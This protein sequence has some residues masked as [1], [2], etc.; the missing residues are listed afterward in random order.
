MIYNWSCFWK[1]F[2]ANQRG[3][4]LSLVPLHLAFKTKSISFHVNWNVNSLLSYYLNSTVYKKE[5]QKAKEISVIPLNRHTVIQIFPSLFRFFYPQQFHKVNRVKNSPASSQMH[6][7]SPFLSLLLLFQTQEYTYTTS[8]SC[9]P[10]VKQKSYQLV[11]RHFED[12]HKFSLHLITIFLCCSVR[13]Y[14]NHEVTISQ[15]CLYT[16]QYMTNSS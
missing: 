15:I 2:P 8:P 6:V 4:Y 13:I 16:I 14:Y 3:K 11:R 10:T 7:T 12:L 5:E 9:F 1:C